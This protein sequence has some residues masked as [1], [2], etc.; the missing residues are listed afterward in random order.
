MGPLSNPGLQR[1]V[2]L[3]CGSQ[4]IEPIRNLRLGPAVRA[5]HSQMSNLA[6]KR[7]P[8]IAIVAP[9]EIEYI[10]RPRQPRPWNAF[11]NAVPNGLLS[12]NLADT[13]GSRDRSLW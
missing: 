9:S 3:G 11:R 4:V 13:L 12:N 10:S 2:L 8:W 5:S 7:K 1:I 6:H